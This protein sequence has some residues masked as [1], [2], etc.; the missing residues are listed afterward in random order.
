MLPGRISQWRRTGILSRRMA[1]T[2]TSDEQAKLDSR[3]RSLKTCTEEARSARWFVTPAD[4]ASHSVLKQRANLSQ[5]H[6]NRSTRY[7][8]VQAVRRMRR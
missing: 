1:L 4:R 8:V 5:G 2:L 6:Y 7:F 3:I